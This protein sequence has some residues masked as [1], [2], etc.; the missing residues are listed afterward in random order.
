M[1]ATP[2]PPKDQPVLHYR[3]GKKYEKS[4]YD[5]SKEGEDSDEI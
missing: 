1:T 3:T 2:I 5:G 4:D